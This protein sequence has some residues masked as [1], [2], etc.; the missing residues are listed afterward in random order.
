MRFYRTM[1]LIACCAVLFMTGALA[2][3]EQYTMA[4]YDS[5][6]TGHVWD[7]NLFFQR[8]ESITGVSFSFQQFTD[9]EEWH[10][11]LNRY[12]SASDLPDVLFK[13]DLTT[14]ETQKLYEQGTIIDLRPYMEDNAPNLYKLLK[15]NNDWEEAISLPDGAIVSLP[16]INPLQ[17]N[18]I[19][20]MN[21]TW[22][23][24]L[25]LEMPKDAD[26]FTEVL[27]AFKTGD[28]N[29]NGK[30]DE[31]PLTFTS[32]WDLRFLA[33]AFGFIGNDYYLEVT[34][35]GSLLCDI[36]DNRYRDFLSWLHVLWEENL[37]DHNGFSSMDTT[38]QIT[39][40]K[41]TIPYGCVFGPT[42][43]NM[44]PASATGDYVV[45]M[46]L[47][48][49]GRMVYRSLLGDIARGTFAITSACKAPEQIMKWVDYL[50]TEEGC[51]LASAG[52]IE[53]EYERTSD[54][55]WYWVDDIQ[56]VQ[57]SVMKDATI[58]DG[59]AMPLYLPES[60]QLQFDDEQ[61]HQAVEQICELNHVSRLSY[62]LIYLSEAQ[63]E[64]LT[65]IWPELGTY[66]ETQ[67]TWFITGDAELTDETWAEFQETLIEKGINTVCDIFESAL[68]QRWTVNE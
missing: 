38:R 27:R 5:T 37:I 46:P 56:T 31:I 11:E 15:S 3:S 23:N 16:T 49:D 22:L 64:Q 17:S 12:G 43:L 68:E 54:G 60:Y 52:Q 24:R 7:D 51:F 50:Y 66:A 34:D 21:Q 32:L 58:A 45:L 10:R 25:G 40:N 4:G 28:P 61:T 44:L 42:A 20:W 47:Q 41:A 63:R 2:E 6:D 59:T 18:N 1:A 8:M 13:A 9:S 65:K 33:H 55:S 35:N 19:I 39:D 30:Q 26:S 67:M 14:A 36:T 53:D 57:D 29:R 62:P 48:Y